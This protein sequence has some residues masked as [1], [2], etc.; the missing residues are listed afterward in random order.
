MVTNTPIKT[1]Q[2]K[3]ELHN[4]DHGERFNR[5]DLPGRLKE[6]DPQSGVHPH[7]G[8]TETEIAQWNDG[9]RSLRKWRGL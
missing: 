5:W 3:N 4:F 8:T 1:M 7:I 2:H 9:D 6:R